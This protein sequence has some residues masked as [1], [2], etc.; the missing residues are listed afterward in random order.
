VFVNF[1]LFLK[2]IFVVFER[3]VKE[4]EGNYIL[5]YFWL[6]RQFLYNK[7]NMKRNLKI[8]KSLTKKVK[9]PQISRNRPQWR[10]LPKK[11][12]GATNTN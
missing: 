11:L 3:D 6:K 8:K 5:P 10:I 2:N 1:I 9:K 12:E 7:K 4:L